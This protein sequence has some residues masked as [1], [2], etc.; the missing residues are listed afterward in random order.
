MFSRNAKAA[1]RTTG[2]LPDCGTVKTPSIRCKYPKLEYFSKFYSAVKS[3][4]QRCMFSGSVV[5]TENCNR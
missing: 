4:I 1:E 3:S 5:Y 2:S